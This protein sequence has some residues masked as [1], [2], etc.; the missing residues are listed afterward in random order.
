MEHKSSIKD[1]VLFGSTI[2]GKLEPNDIDILMIFIKSVDKDIEYEFRKRASK[3]FASISIISKT[4]DNLYDESFSARDAILFEGYS[5]V[6]KRFIASL[7]G[8]DSLGLFMYQTKSMSNA[9][10]TR[11]YYALNGR[12]GSK[13][14]ANSLAAIKISNNMIAIPLENIEAAKNFFDTWKV[15]YSYIPSLLPS[16]LA[17]KHIISKVI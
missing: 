13:G 16:R 7:Y 8:F 3:I 9:A 2:R 14:V 4:E 5:L 15:E 11:F 6:R 10:K 12:R 1:V 17:K